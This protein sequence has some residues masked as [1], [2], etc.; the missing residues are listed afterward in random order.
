MIDLHCHILPGLDDG[1]AD[2]AESIQ[3]ARLAWDDGIR[4]VVATPHSLNGVYYNPVRV[5]VEKVRE[6]NEILK[7]EGI[8]LVVCPGSDMRV[9]SNMVERIAKGDA[10]TI[11]LNGRYVLV[12][13]ALR[14]NAD[15]A[16]KE[17]GELKQ[18]NIT[19]IITHPERN[20]SFQEDLGLLYELV[21]AGCLVQVTGKSIIA[22]M[23]VAAFACAR[24]LLEKRLVHVIASDAHTTGCRPPILSPA[25]AAAAKILGDDEMAR[26]MVTTWPAAILAGEPV[27]VPAPIPLS[28]KKRKWW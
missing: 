24:T 17:L 28:D 7:T 4:T 11:N 23:G 3:M 21:E 15:E 14:V 19:P 12:E 20:L 18:N 2:V 9:C 27:T 16:R 10:L 25:V 5:V 6:L 13:F 8:D 1:A 26:K 22:E